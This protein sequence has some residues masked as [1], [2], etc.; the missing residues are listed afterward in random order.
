[1]CGLIICINNTRPPTEDLNTR[2]AACHFKPVLN[3]VCGTPAHSSRETTICKGPS[4][5]RCVTLRRR[6][7]R[8]R[9]HSL[10]GAQLKPGTWMEARSLRLKADHGSATRRKRLGDCAGGARSTGAPTKPKWAV[11]CGSGGKVASLRP[12]ADR[13]IGLTT[14]KE[15][16]ARV[17]A[18]ARILR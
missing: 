8:L 18:F 4:Q 17:Q 11:T 5:T 13:A 10:F 14:L 6:L 15:C 16:R 7:V 1:M 12:S 9:Q 3:S 2:E